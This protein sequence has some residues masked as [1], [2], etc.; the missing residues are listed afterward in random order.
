MKYYH[1]TSVKID[2]IGVLYTRTIN[3]DKVEDISV[4][5]DKLKISFSAVIRDEDGS[6]KDKSTTISVPLKMVDSITTEVRSYF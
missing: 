4:A 1:A 3:L 2:L 6:L 5:K